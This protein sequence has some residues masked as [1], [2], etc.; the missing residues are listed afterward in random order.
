MKEEDQRTS[1]NTEFDGISKEYP[2]GLD[3]FNLEN[4]NTEK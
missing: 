4:K 3:K 2:I 1:L